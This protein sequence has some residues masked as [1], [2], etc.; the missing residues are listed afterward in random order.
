MADNKP[1][2]VDDSGSVIKWKDSL[3]NEH[4]TAKNPETIK[5]FSNANRATKSEELAPKTETVTPA[6]AT[7]TAPVTSAGATGSWD[8]IGSGPAPGTMVP[9]GGQSGVVVPVA[10]A[11][12]P[13]VSANGPRVVTL[14]DEKSRTEGITKGAQKKWDEAGQKAADAVIQQG[15]AQAAGAAAQAELFKN[16]GMRLQQENERRVKQQADRPAAMQKRLDEVDVINKKFSDAK[17]DQKHIWGDEGTGN[18]FFAAL[19][20]A[21]GALGSGLN[22]KPNAA[23]DIVNRAIDRDIEV[24]KANLEQIG[25]SSEVA[26]G[27]LADYMKVTGD[28]DAAIAAERA[29]QLAIFENQLKT[30]ASSSQSAEAKAAANANAA[31]VGEQLAGEQAKV[32]KFIYEKGSQDAQGKAGE[33]LPEGAATKL[34]DKQSAISDLEQIQKMKKAIDTGRVSGNWIAAG[35]YLGFDSP[36]EAEFKRKLDVML[37]K[38]AKS[39]FGGQMSDT[40]LSF[41]KDTVPSLYDSDVNFDAKLDGMLKD[42]R[43]EFERDNKYWQSQGYRMPN[44]GPSASGIVEKPAPGK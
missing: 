32:N 20:I 3:G 7:T 10:P 39:N 19:G 36:D 8:A 4:E 21:L 22:G 14:D 27:G 6:P 17:I 2:V 12:P 40:D 5:L 23:L 44:T 16:E 18:R 9:S 11:T 29:R 35:Q 1:T 24:Q 34:K 28:Q 43:K 13:I 26:R 41:I 38:V 42:Q 25:K 15:E 37:L 30:A 33:P 31:K